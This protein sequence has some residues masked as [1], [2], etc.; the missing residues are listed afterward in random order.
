MPDN[1]TTAYTDTARC[2]R[3][4]KSTTRRSHSVVRIQTI[5]F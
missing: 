2:R 5:I 3:K 4:A 1:Q